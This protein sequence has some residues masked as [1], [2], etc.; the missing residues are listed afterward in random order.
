MTKFSRSGP[1][2]AAALCAL[3]AGAASAQDF[4]SANG[5]TVHFYGQLNLGYL[6]FDDGQDTDN[7]FG[8][9]GNSTSRLGFT[10]DH[11]ADIGAV[12]FR[13]ETGLGLGS[14]GS[15]SQSGDDPEV[16]DWNRRQLRK[17]EVVLTNDYG[18]FSV[19][20]GSMATDGAGGLDD[21]GTTLAGTKSFGDVAGSYLFRNADGTLSSLS[22]SDVFHNTDGSRRMRVRYD[23]PEYYGF[24]V[25]AAYGREVL[26]EDNDNDY[27]DAAVN[28][29]GDV[30]DFKIKA[31]VGANWVDQADDAGTEKT[32][33]A[34]ATIMHAS[35]VNLTLAGG[36]DFNS[37]GDWEYAKLGYTTA[38]WTQ[39]GETSVAVEY[40]ETDDYGVEGA[41]GEAWGLLLTQ[42]IKPLNAEAYV[43]YRHYD[44]SAP[45]ASFQDAQSLLIGSRWSF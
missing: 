22:V 24:T 4:T 17:L 40:L 38:S 16:I 19:G 21:S 14:T 12:R 7:A 11:D 29:A 8:N 39:V 1:I 44:V 13:F 3:T 34:S 18:V 45:G 42:K 25:G 33:V 23:T 2:A 32:G 35:G 15:F 37:S 6:G 9:V 43:G 10:L 36:G 28:W 31:S 41:R 27:Y 30:G 20:Q 5:D 26:A